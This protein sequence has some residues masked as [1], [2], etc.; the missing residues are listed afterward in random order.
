MMA[1][2]LSSLDMDKRSQEHKI[3][4]IVDSLTSKLFYHGH[5]I[6]RSEAKEEVG[7]RYTAQ[8]PI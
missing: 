7:R 2:K 8:R 5:P 3:E 4:E 1:R 6:N